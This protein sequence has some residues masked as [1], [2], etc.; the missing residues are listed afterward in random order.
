M[1]DRRTRRVSTAV[2]Q[3]DHAAFDRVGHFHPV[4]GNADVYLVKARGRRQCEAAGRRLPLAAFLIK[5]LGHGWLGRRPPA[6]EH[7]VDL[8]AGFGTDHYA[9]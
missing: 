4:R 6:S 1:G 2:E 7:P 3:Q 5:R 9:Q 8:G